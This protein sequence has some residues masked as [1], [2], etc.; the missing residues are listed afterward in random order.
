VGFFT[1]ILFLAR[2]KQLILKVWPVRVEE[3]FWTQPQF[4]EILKVVAL[5]GSLRHLE[6]HYGDTDIAV[7]HVEELNEFVARI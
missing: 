3:D 7:E 2:L 4:V 6:F 5:H 1:F